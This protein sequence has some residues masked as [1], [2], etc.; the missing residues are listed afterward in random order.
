MKHTRRAFIKKTALTGAFI[1]LAGNLL[2]K[3]E[4]G[5]SREPKIY[6]FTK[7]LDKYET[8]FMAE[9]L[10]MSG[11]D[12]FDLTVRRGGKVEPV[13][14]SDDLPRVVEVGKKYNL[15]TDL[16]VTDITGPVDRQTR[17]VLEIASSVGVRHYRLGWYDY[18]LSAGIL[19]TLELVRDRIKE[20][21]DVNRYYGIQAGY[22]NHSGGKVG[23]PGWDVWEMIKDYPVETIS[24]QYDVRHATVE[25]NRSWLFILHLLSSNIGSLAIKDFTWEITNGKA[26]VLNVPLGEGQVDFKM[27]FNTLKELNINVPITLH[28]EYP[29]LRVPEE[30]LSLLEKQKIIVRKI[31]KDVRF[32]RE[33]MLD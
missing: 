31:K 10:A 26:H 9:T 18:D 30:N 13:R 20:L 28:I 33:H 11:V 23:S 15:A 5:D 3:A 1:P 25:G 27:Y 12:G 22:Q 14:V 2:S 32:I 4:I 21:S 8:G 24:S 19:K 29:L 16:I 6:Y 7:D 17:E